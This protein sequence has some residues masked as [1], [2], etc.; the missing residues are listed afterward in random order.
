MSIAI[1]GKPL[2]LVNLRLLIISSPYNAEKGLQKISRAPVIVI[3][4]I[5]YCCKEHPVCS[6]A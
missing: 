5:Q 6:A 2:T 4:T 3:N 1:K